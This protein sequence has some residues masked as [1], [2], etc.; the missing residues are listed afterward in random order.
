MKKTYYLIFIYSLYINISNIQA[1]S[2]TKELDAPAKVVQTIFDVAK[3]NQFALLTNLCDI[4]KEN[5]KDTHQICTMQEYANRMQNDPEA[6]K[7]VDEFVAL[8]KNG[9]IVGKTSYE[10]VDDT[11]IAYVV[12]NVGAE[13]ERQEIITLIKRGNN[14]FLYQF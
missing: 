2:L 11:F 12:V 6:K 5:D 10:Q 13:K 8:F 9:E 3:N 14:W 4:K 1:Q 7:K